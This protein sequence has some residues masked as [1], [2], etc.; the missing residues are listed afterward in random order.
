LELQEATA[1]KASQIER[2]F[3]EYQRFGL[4]FQNASGVIAL[5]KYPAAQ[6]KQVKQAPREAFSPQT[7]PGQ[8]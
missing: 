3:D 1:G 2:V 5:S 4:H 7:Q 8:R 6:E